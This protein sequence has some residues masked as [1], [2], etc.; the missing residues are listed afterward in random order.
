MLQVPEFDISSKLAQF[1]GDYSSFAATLLATDSTKT[2]YNSNQS[3]DSIHVGDNSQNDRFDTYFEFHKFVL[4]MCSP[5]YSASTS[6]IRT[7]YALEFDDSK[8]RLRM[9]HMKWENDMRAQFDVANNFGTAFFLFF[10]YLKVASF[11]NH[12]QKPLPSP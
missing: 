5:H 1:M 9:L 2:T 11:E 7:C 3:D 12:C 10:I 8:T 6:V 4:Q